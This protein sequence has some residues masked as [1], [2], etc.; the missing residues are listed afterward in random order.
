MCDRPVCATTTRL[1]KVK[2]EEKPTVGIDLATHLYEFIREIRGRVNQCRAFFSRVSSYLSN[3][4]TAHPELKEYAA[5]LEAMI[6]DAKTRSKGI[7]A[8]PLSEVQRKVDGIKKRLRKEQPTAST[9]PNWTCATLR[10]HR[11]I[12]AA[13]YA[14]LGHEIGANRGF[15]VR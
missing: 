11:M 2:K 9:V 15:E 6:A 4:K 12:F 10:A 8:T 5:E 1:S 7:Y 3:E 13:E 14:P